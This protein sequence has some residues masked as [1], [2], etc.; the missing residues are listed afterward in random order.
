PK[1]VSYVGPLLALDGGTLAI[2]AKHDFSPPQSNLLLY[3]RN[4]GQWTLE[5]TFVANPQAVKNTPELSYQHLAIHGKRVAVSSVISGRYGVQVYE[6]NG[7]TWKRLPSPVLPAGLSPTA[8]SWAGEALLIETDKKPG[9]DA[10]LWVL[11]GGTWKA[12]S[13]LRASV[14]PEDTILARRA[15]AETVMLADLGKVVDTSNTFGSSYS[16]SEA[17]EILF[18]DLG[19]MSVQDGPASVISPSLAGGSTLDFGSVMVGETTTRV[20]T[21]S[22]DT[23][24]PFTL[25]SVTISGP[26]AADFKI[27]FPV[28]TIKTGESK[29]FRLEHLPTGEGRQEATLL[30]QGSIRPLSFRLL[31]QAR[32]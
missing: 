6:R 8:L 9:N 10:A 18:Y 21:V 16:A 31:S 2:A 5:A 28:T 23:P 32:T 15:T 14:G 27:T 29:T 1:Q 24:L 17:P 30:I 19:S 11:Q 26:A 13:S 4:N 3:H 20:I 22:N 25:S 7:T 12:L